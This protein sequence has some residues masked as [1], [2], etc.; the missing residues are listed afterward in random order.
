M[1]PLILLLVLAGCAPH[2]PP[3][4]AAQSDQNVVLF[5]QGRHTLQE[6]FTAAEQY[7]R[8]RS[9]ASVFVRTER[10]DPHSVLDYFE[11]RAA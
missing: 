11:C 8:A 10:V 3:T 7:C 6:S 9:R 1:R 4:I 5:R 2:T